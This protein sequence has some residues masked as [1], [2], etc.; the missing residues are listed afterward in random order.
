MCGTLI[1]FSKVFGLVCIEFTFRGYYQ[2]AN[3]ALGTSLSLI[4][5][6]TLSILAYLVLMFYTRRLLKLCMNAPEV[7]FSGSN[8]QPVYFGFV[9]K[10]INPIIIA[11]DI[12]GSAVSITAI[13]SFIIQVFYLLTLIYFIENYNRRIESI[14][15]YTQVIVV[16]IIGIAMVKLILSDYNGQEGVII[17]IL[18]PFSLFTIRVL[19]K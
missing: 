10:L 16:L 13:V 9:A 14:Q 15:R 8:S 11:L 5:V 12:S 19:N 17:L 4:I 1:V 6:N 3:A 7:P 2:F 18:L